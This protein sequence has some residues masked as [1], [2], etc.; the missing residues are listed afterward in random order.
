MIHLFQHFWASCSWHMSFSNMTL[1]LQYS[2]T[3]FRR[4]SA[5]RMEKWP[6]SDAIFHEKS[7]RS[8]HFQLWKGFQH[9]PVTPK[10]WK[11]LKIVKCRP[12]YRFRSLKIIELMFLYFFLIF[13]WPETT[14]GP[15]L[16]QGRNRTLPNFMNRTDTCLWPKKDKIRWEIK[17]KFVAHGRKS[18]ASVSYNAKNVG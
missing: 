9:L 17:K 15:G 11:L 7:L 1:H 6:F 13:L 10:I 16:A 8:N 4:K 3:P 5:M 2:Q 12:D 18:R 14:W